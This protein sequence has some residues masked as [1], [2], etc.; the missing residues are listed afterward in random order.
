MAKCGGLLKWW[1]PKTIGEPK[2]DHFGRVLG[3][4]PFRE[5][6]G[7]TN[8]GKYTIH[9]SSEN[10]LD[11]GDGSD[12]YFRGAEGLSVRM[13]DITFGSPKSSTLF[14]HQRKMDGH[15]K[16]HVFTFFFSTRRWMN[17]LFVNLGQFWW[18]WDTCCSQ[19]PAT[20]SLF[21]ILGERTC[22]ELW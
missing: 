15:G 10:R 17:F 9:G 5:T 14:F 3:V 6:H 19:K 8:V 20:L 18:H 13:F 16:N 11:S 7:N 21:F 2:N 12:D 1:Y 4:P 22:Q